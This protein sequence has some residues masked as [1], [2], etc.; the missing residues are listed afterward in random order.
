MRK[1]LY[2]NVALKNGLVGSVFTR[3]SIMLGLFCAGVVVI[4]IMYQ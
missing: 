4:A 1:T 3:R 2:S